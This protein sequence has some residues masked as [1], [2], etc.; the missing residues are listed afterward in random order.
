M[1][2]ME[3]PA[4][5]VASLTVGDALDES[6][7][8]RNGAKFTGLVVDCFS[9]ADF[10]PAFR[11]CLTWHNIKARLVHGGCLMLNL[12]GS[13]PLPLPA[14]YFEVMA[15]VAEVFGPERVWVHCGTGNL[16]VVAAERAIDWAAVAERL[17][18]ELTHL[19]N[20]PWQSY[21]HFLLQQQ[22]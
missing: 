11:S 5:E 15:G 6:S 8:P 1:S 17:P 20:T 14:A 9:G 22:H 2:L 3:L 13:T 18:S 7:V 16:V 21:P 10:P 19:M 4:G 12:G